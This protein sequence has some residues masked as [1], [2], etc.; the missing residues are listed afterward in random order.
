MSQTNLEREFSEF[1][2]Q[3]RFMLQRSR[4][5]G[6]YVFFPRAIAPSSGL[7][8]LEWVAASGRGTVHATTVVRARPP[9]QPYNVA[10]VELEEGPR[11]MTRVEGVAPEAVRI[12]MP[13][14][15]RISNDGDRPLLV[16]D[17][18]SEQA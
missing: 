5:S 4:G 15:A 9:Q 2:A 6:D 18:A 12:G 3:G 17:V 7:A 11:L 8:D 1:L 14:R 10:L 13:V 16:F